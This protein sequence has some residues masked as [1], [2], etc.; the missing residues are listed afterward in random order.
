MAWIYLQHQKLGKQYFD[1]SNPEDIEK[2][3]KDVEV[4]E[5][6]AR[7]IIKNKISV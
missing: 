3:K 2:L 4:I 7:K 6:E 1:P 5:N